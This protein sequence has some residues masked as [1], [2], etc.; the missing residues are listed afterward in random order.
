M[1]KKAPVKT[2]KKRELGTSNDGD[3]PV[4]ECYTIVC[5]L[6]YTEKVGIII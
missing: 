6:F 1:E 5:V 4:S 2:I 3:F